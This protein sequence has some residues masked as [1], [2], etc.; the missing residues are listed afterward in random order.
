MAPAVEHVKGAGTGARVAQRE[1]A[2]MFPL[3]FT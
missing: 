3:C 1:T 2:K